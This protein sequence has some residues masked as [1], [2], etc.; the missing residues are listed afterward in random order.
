ML[1]MNF[2]AYLTRLRAD[3]LAKP[4]GQRKPIPTLTE[5]AKE[6]DVT[7]SQLSRFIGGKVSK[8]DR[9]MGGALIA[10]MRR[11]GFDTKITDLLRYEG[12]LDAPES[13]AGS[14]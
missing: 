10:A 14:E 12:P 9:K 4:E 2:K 3:E 7:R 13:V 5:L 8:I 1:V 6:I 11:R